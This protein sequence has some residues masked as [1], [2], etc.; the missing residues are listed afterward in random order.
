MF[1]MGETAFYDSTATYYLS[2]AG[3]SIIVMS[4]SAFGFFVNMPRVKKFRFNV[5]TMAAG[6]TLVFLLCVIYLISE[7]YNPFL[8]FR[9]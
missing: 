3:L 1:G 9:F 2:S 6:Y 8:Y 7:T 5:A 4:L